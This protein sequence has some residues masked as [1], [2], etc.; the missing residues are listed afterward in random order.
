MRSYA[1]A[2]VKACHK[3]GAPAIGGMAALI[4]IKSDAAANEKALAGVR[5]DKKRDAND[6]FDGGWIAHPGLVQIALE[7]FKAV[8]GDKPNQWGKQRDETFNARDLLNFVPEQTITE[9]G[10]RNTIN[11][12]S[13]TSQL[14]SRKRLCRSTISWKTRRPRRYRARR[15]QGSS[16]RRACSTTRCRR[17]RQVPRDSR[18]APRQDERRCRR[19]R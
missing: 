13:T 1:L 15:S 11:V 7:E 2:L 16:V 6:G 18:R 12:S 9:D 19:R 14:A 5:H 17:L 4:P 3:R 8:L 10:E